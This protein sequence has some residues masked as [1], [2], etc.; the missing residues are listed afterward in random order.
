MSQS[1]MPGSSMLA[2]YLQLGVLILVGGAIYPLVYLRQNFEVPILDSFGITIVELGQCYSLL[3]VIFVITYLPSGWLADRVSPKWLLSISLALTSLLGMWFSTMPGFQVLLVIFAGWGIATGLTFWAALIKGVAVLADRHEQGRFFGLLDGGRGLVEAILATVA[4]TLFAYSLDAAGQSTSSAL[5][6][7]IY[8]Y[9]G[10]ALILSP[11]VL[12]VLSDKG[13]ERKGE[14]HGI[15][16]QSLWQDIKS[17]AVNVD[18]WLAAFCLL[19][20]YQLFW[21]TYSF[22]GYMQQVYGIT[23]VAAGTITVAKLWTRPIGA[24]AAG[25]LGDR[26]N[27][28]K[29]LAVL[30]FAG[31]VTLM[32]L[33]F[34][35]A[36]AHVNVLLGVVLLVGLTTYAIRGIYWATL[37]GCHIPYRTKGLAIGMMS[38]VGY[39]PD[40]YLPLVNGFILDRFPGKLGYSYYFSGIVF[41]GFLGTL[42]AL[43]L[44]SRASKRGASPE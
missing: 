18:L 40:I 44:M 6:N 16:G 29:T 30:M 21:A 17:L 10:Y 37:D 27:L 13:E 23:A 14:D 25:F 4:I 36:D 32:G 1:E 42:A 22:A 2:R 8:L 31:T 34:L 26:F 39:A 24:I 12:F 5:Q 20:G 28:E 3:G 41:M 33:I 15:S 11:I 38:F 9:I 19:C 35:P 7:V 43:Y